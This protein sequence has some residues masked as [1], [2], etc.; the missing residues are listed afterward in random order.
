VFNLLGEEVAILVTGQ[1]TAGQHVQELNAAN[2]SSGMY[3]YRLQAGTFNET[4]KLVVL[5]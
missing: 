4:K 2:L 5:K 1:I 3:F